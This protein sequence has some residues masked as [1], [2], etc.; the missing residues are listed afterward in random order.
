MVRKRQN[1]AVCVTR[2]T[3]M[4]ETVFSDTCSA[5][6]DVGEDGPETWDCHIAGGWTNGQSTCPLWENIAKLCQTES[7]RK[8]LHRYLSYTKHRQFPMLLPQTWIGIAE[9]RRTST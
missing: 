8:F 7:E 6:E 3:V 9:R 5:P 4:D 2:G 1:P